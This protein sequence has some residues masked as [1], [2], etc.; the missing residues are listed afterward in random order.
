MPSDQAAESAPDPGAFT[1]ILRSVEDSIVHLSDA[2]KL[3]LIGRIAQ[4]VSITKPDDPERIRRQYENRIR[5]I[6]QMEALPSVSND[7]G[8]SNRDHDKVL[9][10]TPS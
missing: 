7:D 6:E 9:Y 3:E 4:S 1:R 8:F 10:S 5:L 2:E